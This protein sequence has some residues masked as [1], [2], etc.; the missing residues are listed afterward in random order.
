MLLTPSSSRL[1]VK[2]I[3]SFLKFPR[4]C[5][6]VREFRKETEKHA[7]ITKLYLTLMKKHIFQVKGRELLKKGYDDPKI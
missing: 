1:K 7:Y 5:K 2:Q 6:L 3:L 4:I